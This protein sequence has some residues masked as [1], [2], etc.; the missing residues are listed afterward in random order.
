MTLEEVIHRIGTSDINQFPTLR[1]INQA[2]LDHV[3][4]LCGGKK[5]I[6]AHVLGMNRRTLYRRRESG[7][8]SLEVKKNE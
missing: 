3:L 7:S 4:S 1:Q 6:A 2:Y 8:L 5:A